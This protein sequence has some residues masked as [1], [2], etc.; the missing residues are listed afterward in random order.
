M[1]PVKMSPYEQGDI[2]IESERV[3]TSGGYFGASA[4]REAGVG[5]LGESAPARVVGAILVLR[6]H[7]Q[8]YFSIR[9]LTFARNVSSQPHGSEEDGIPERLVEA[10]TVHFT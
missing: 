1:A 7:H 5:S 4:V 6:E 10:G 3:A 2:R 9:L 8:R